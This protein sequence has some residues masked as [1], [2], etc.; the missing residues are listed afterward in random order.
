MDGRPEPGNRFGQN[1][2]YKPT[3]HHFTPR[4]CPPSDQ[5]A[6]EEWDSS[7]EGP[8]AF[9]SSVPEIVSSSEAAEILNISRQRVH[10]LRKDHPTFPAPL[11]ELQ[12]RPLWTRDSI[13]W[14]DRTWERKVG[15]PRRG[16]ML[17]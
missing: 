8:G 1:P 16:D 2:A 5:D 9:V 13:E 17:R 12:S 10:Q 15:R 14:F 3:R 6:I 4:P 7:L 11:Y